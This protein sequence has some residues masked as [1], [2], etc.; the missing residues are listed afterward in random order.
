[1]NVVSTI[2]A[3]AL[4]ASTASAK[5]NNPNYSDRDVKNSISINIIDFDQESRSVELLYADESY[6]YW[7]DST[8]NIAELVPRNQ[9]QIVETNM[10][11][12]LFS[13]LKRKDPNTLTDIIELNDGTRIRSIILDIDEDGIQYFTG[14]SLKRELMPASSIYMLH[15]DNGTVSIPFPVIAPDYAAL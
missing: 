12:N 8:E 10:N 7:V 3:L 4:V 6:F 9:V 11:V 1:M 15:I 13:L 14:K 5:S 2:I